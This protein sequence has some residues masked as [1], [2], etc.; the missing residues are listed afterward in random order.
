MRALWL[1]VL[2]VLFA[3]S[4]AHAEAEHYENVRLDAGITASSVSVSDRKGTGMAV[5][6][7]GMAHDN[8]AIGGRVEFAVLF[9]GVIGN[10]EAP[11][12]VAIAASGLLKAEYLFGTQAIRPFVG[13]GIGGY[14]IG[15]QTIDAGPDRDG[16]SRTTGRYLGVAPQVGID[17][18]R[19]RIAAT[20][21]AILGAYLELHQTIGNV[22]ETR[23]LSQNYLSLEFSIQFAGGRKAGSPSGVQVPRDR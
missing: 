22:E 2:V 11:L 21:N 18:G 4:D 19:V 1:G 23:K 15:A 14:T 3:G 20:Y 13:F 7:K 12:D 17:L 6:I 10:D 16:I 8:L 5:E 9:G